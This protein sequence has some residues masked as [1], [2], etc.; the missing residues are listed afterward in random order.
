MGVGRTVFALAKSPSAL[1]GD[2]VGPNTAANAILYAGTPRGV[3]RT[4]D[5]GVNW[6]A[7][8]AFLGNSIAT[9]KVHN[10]AG[11]GDVVYAGTS[12]AGVWVYA[13]GGWTNYT[14]GLG[15]AV[16]ATDPVL[17]R[18]SK[19]NGYIDN[20]DVLDGARS[21]TW[22][23][24]CISEIAN[25]GIFALTGTVSGFQGNYTVTDQNGPL[26]QVGNLIEFT[27]VDGEVDFK[28][29]DTF[30]FKTVRD[31]GKNITDLAVDMS[32]QKLYAITYFWGPLEAHAIGDV[33]V[34]ELEVDGTMAAGAWKTVNV[35]LPQHEPPDDTSLFPQHVL[36]FDNPAAPG[37]MFL[38]GEGIHLFKAEDSSIGGLSDF[39]ADDLQWHD[40]E[41]G[42]KNKI[43]TRTPVLFTGPVAVKV[44]QV[45]KIANPIRAGAFD[46]SLELLVEDRYGNPPIVGSELVM[47]TYRQEG[48]DQWF[49]TTTTLKEWG[50]EIYTIGTYRDGPE[51]FSFVTHGYPGGEPLYWPITVS[52][53][54]G[55]AA[56]YPP[57]TDQKVKLEFIPGRY[58]NGATIP[59]IVAP[60]NSGGGWAQEWTP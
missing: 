52:F 3:Y 38:G 36:E 55:P 19:G 42:L 45:S 35:N 17:A 20:L 2:G 46:Y 25:S 43:V 32:R 54:V 6:A 51:N 11:I 13:N 26:Y 14:T 33:Y 60:G 44:Y 57:D 5:G 16:Q 39:D 1:G 41:M 47:T 53:T 34:H 40:S 24:K 28:M 12:D 37:A 49:T 30:S 50:D 23:M 4:Q 59:T 31:L 21:E 7:L 58:D 27:L 10:D 56:P 18:E 8:P 15:K 9:L 48:V 22:I 29:G